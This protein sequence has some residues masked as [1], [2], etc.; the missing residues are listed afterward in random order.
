MV[1]ELAPLFTA[2]K[3][4]TLWAGFLLLGIGAIV[5]LAAW[6]RFGEY[7]PA[8]AAT[9]SAWPS[10]T[11]GLDDERCPMLRHRLTRVGTERTGSKNHLDVFGMDRAS[12]SAAI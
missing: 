12:S 11:R 3:W 1:A 7:L 6:R 4:L 9:M 2:G 10:W 5:A 8:V